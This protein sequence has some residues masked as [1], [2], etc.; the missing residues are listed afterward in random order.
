[1]RLTRAP[2]ISARRS[3]R[4]IRFFACGV[5]A[6][7]VPLEDEMKRA[8]QTTAPAQARSL[9]TRAPEVNRPRQP[10]AFDSALAAWAIE[11][12]AAAFAPAANRR[13]ATA[14]LPFPAVDAPLP[15]EIAKLAVGP[16]IVAKR[17]AAGFDR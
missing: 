15:G 13:C 7:L 11:G 16:R 8:R 12:R 9:R 5:F 3:L 10:P 17:R 6:I 4:R 1:M 2:L 14:R